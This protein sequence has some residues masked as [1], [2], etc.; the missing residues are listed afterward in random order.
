MAFLKTP[1][2][3]LTPLR[4][5]VG[6]YLHGNSWLGMFALLRKLIPLSPLVFT[7]VLKS[8]K[9]MNLLQRGEELG[10]FSSAYEDCPPQGQS[11]LTSPDK[12]A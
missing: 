5:I 12:D 2:E 9:F 4:V 7:T 3:I 1:D 8:I 10:F 11:P 6:G